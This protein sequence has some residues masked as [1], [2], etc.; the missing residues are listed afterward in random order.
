MGGVS[1]QM[2]TRED[3]IANLDIYPRTLPCIAPRPLLP[4][5]CVLKGYSDVLGT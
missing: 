1:R 2:L 5:L 4:F 3:Q